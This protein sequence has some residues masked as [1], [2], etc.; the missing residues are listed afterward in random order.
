ML[1]KTVTSLA[2]ATACLTGLATIPA[3][4]QMAGPGGP[5]PTYSAPQNYQGSPNYQGAMPSSSA[6]IGGTEVISNGPQGSPPANWSA[7]QNVVASQ[8]YDRMLET[9]RGFREARM[10]K[11]CGPIT[12]PQL[13]QQCL[14]SFTQDEPLMGSSSPR[15]TSRSDYGR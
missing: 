3:Q 7:R 5:P 10:R 11:E 12:D 8:R 13:H 2:F 6:G 1:S 9:S 14:A 15:R 4:A